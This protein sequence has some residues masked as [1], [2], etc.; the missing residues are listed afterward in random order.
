MEL[1]PY[2]KPFVFKQAEPFRGDTGASPTGPLS[3]DETLHATT[4]KLERLGLAARPVRGPEVDQHDTEST[5]LV[6]GEV[7]APE[8]LDLEELAF[9]DVFYQSTVEEPPA[10]SHCRTEVWH[11]DTSASILCIT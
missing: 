2:A 1:N 4:A 5:T 11:R 6:H 7:L 9:D 8:A 10:V 3:S